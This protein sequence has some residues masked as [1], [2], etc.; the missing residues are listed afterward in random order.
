VKKDERFLIKDLYQVHLRQ[1]LKA[2][3]VVLLFTCGISFS[4]AHILPRST[5]PQYVADVSGA[6]LAAWITLRWN[7][8][9]REEKIALENWKEKIT[10]QAQRVNFS[11]SIL[12]HMS[13]EQTQVNPTFL[14]SQSAKLT[15]R[16]QIREIRSAMGNGVGVVDGLGPERE[17]AD[18]AIAT[19]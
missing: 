19:A 8:S 18:A 1:A 7:W 12:Q 5:Y 17:R 10:Q 4:T 3:L 2:G 14:D 6:F 16:R 9:L 11:L 13:D 15:L